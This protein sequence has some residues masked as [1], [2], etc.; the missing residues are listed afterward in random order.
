LDFSR[1]GSAFGRTGIAIVVALVL[2]LASVLPASAQQRALNLLAWADYVDPKVLAD[3]T[4][5]TGI[6]VVYDTYDSNDAALNRL[7]GK[8]ADFDVVIISG[9]VLAQAVK[10]GQL[11]P[12]TAAQSATF[13]ML[14]PEVSERLKVHDPGNRH[15]LT[16]SWGTV[17]LGIN[18]KKIQERLGATAPINTW[19]IVLKPDIAMR[20]KDCGIAMPD[21]PDDIVPVA[22][23]QTGARADS[24]E[25]RDQQKAFDALMRVRGTVRKFHASDHINGLASGD[26]CVA[27]SSSI[28]VMQARKQ[29]EDARNGVEISHVIPRE[30]APL[31]FDVLAMPAGAINQEAASLFIAFM[32]EPAI[33]ARTADFLNAA[34]GS[35][36][37][38]ALTTQGLR[39]TP[40]LVPDEATF[41][42]LYAVPQL[43]GQARQNLL[44]QWQ[45]VKTGK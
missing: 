14:W 43:E 4:A 28:D 6:N 45:R 35:K 27:V 39:E 11:K 40:G 26:I 7:Q 41:K 18:R 13:S 15:A 22:L 20:L 33:A 31:W 25:P 29:A 24:R 12:F 17:G 16:Y 36:A 32:S 5:K 2:S 44:R 42:K 8:A 10:A 37:A 21:S 23:V 9:Q 3:F 30:G 19:D 38:I 1:P 34:T